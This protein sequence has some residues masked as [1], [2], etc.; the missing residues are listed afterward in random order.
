MEEHL[1]RLKGF[2]GN[3]CISSFTK[4]SARFFLGQIVGNIDG[5]TVISYVEA[6]K[7]SNRHVC[8]REYVREKFLLAVLRGSSRIIIEDLD[9]WC[10][11]KGSYNEAI[12]EEFSSF[13][14]RAS[15]AVQVIGFVGPGT[16]LD[17]NEPGLVHP[18]VVRS[19]SDTLKVPRH[20]DFA[21][22]I[23]VIK[24]LIKE[25]RFICLDEEEDLVKEV[26]SQLSG[27]GFEDIIRVLTDA[28]SGSDNILPDIVKYLE[29]SKVV[30]TELGWDRV[31]GQAEAKGA[32]EEASRILWDHQLRS[33]YD[34]LGVRPPLGI[35]LYGPPG[36]GKTLL[37]KE[38]ADHTAV[39]F[40]AVTIPELVHA[41]VGR[42][43]Q[44]LARLFTTAKSSQP[45]IIFIDELDALFASGRASPGQHQDPGTTSTKLIAQLLLEFDRVAKDNAKVLVI[46]ATNNL[47]L[48]EPALLRFGRFEALVEVKPEPGMKAAAQIIVSGLEKLP[49]NL[50]DP[51]CLEVDRVEAHL[52]NLVSADD[53]GV[54]GAMAAQI[55][56][57][58][59]RTAMLQNHPVSLMHIQCNLNLN[60]KK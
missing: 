14:D 29:S 25:K 9:L 22:R 21:D 10:P 60:T 18:A 6:K 33:A 24:E 8:S 58:A 17:V 1:R 32:L 38:L 26:A 54:S 46:G 34:R 19:F 2:P 30:K 13:L 47:G 5:I 20:L 36:T 59:K 49:A 42:S 11:S 37:A 52:L 27:H 31:V 45:S 23:W 56:D 4:E 35:L 51:A 15:T 57:H 55:L 44:S 43:E 41:E 53:E 12:I 40:H 16:D 3:F 50:V 39:H 48:L 7:H 28:Y